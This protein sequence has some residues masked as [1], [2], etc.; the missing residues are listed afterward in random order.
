MMIKNSFSK[1]KNKSI[2]TKLDSIKRK[3]QRHHQN[4]TQKKNNSLT[5]IH[6]QTLMINLLSKKVLQESQEW[7]LHQPL[8]QAL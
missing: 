8:N 6:I 1:Q 7:Y 2:L 4:S 3:P 5:L